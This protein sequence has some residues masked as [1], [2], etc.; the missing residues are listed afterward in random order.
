MTALPCARLARPGALLL[1]LAAAAA[2]AAAPLAA[3]GDTPAPAA[4]PA[5]AG[6]TPLLLGAQY[7]FVEQQ[8]TALASPYAGTLSL[9]ADGDRQA[10][11]TIG[12]YGGW[13][14]AS[15]AQ[16]YLD[17][18]K[19]MGAGVS[20]ATGLGG[21]TNGDVVREGVAGLKKEFYIARLYARFMLPLGSAVAPLERA[22]DQIP[23][24]EAVRRLELKV[25]RLALPD[26]FDHNRYAGSTRTEFMNW[27]LWENTAWDYAA[28]TRGYSDGF[29]V[30]YVSPAWSL[31]YGMFRMPLYANGQTLE[32][33]AR[34]RGENL[35]LTLAPPALTAVVRLLAWRNTARMGDYAEA[36]ALAGASG[37]LPNVAADDRDGRHKSG[38]GV[39][40]EQ[41]LADDGESGLFMRLG[42]NDGRTETFA[43]TEVDRLLSFG[44]QLSGVHW[45]RG[46]DRFGLAAAVEGLSGLHR[47][48]LAAG[49]S[50]FLLGD[51]RLDYARE[52]ILEAYYRVQWT[53]GRGPTALRLQLSPD[54]QYIRDPGFNADRGPVRF[55][56]LRL[57]LE[58]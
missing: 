24:T 49:G 41:P 13:A 43:F 45:H 10:T 6:N 46:E 31:K 22:Q 16:L 3:P 48:Y 53:L 21:L 44:G 23:G 12:F 57:H 55:Y 17:T 33:L 42:W 5:P 27:S 26:D 30:G 37:A 32:T 52:Q 58:Y 38:Y 9:H 19:F 1:V 25:G 14:P 50:G 56:A 28:N 18:E 39:N 15:W 20:G 34:A 40:A 54:V 7:T 11:H 4:V 35:E 36:L 2:R 29:V 51:G 47:E 8:Q